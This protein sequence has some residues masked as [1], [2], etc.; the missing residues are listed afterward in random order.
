M[1]GQNH[2]KFMRRLI[3]FKLRGEGIEVPPGIQCNHPCSQLFNGCLSDK[4]LL[5]LFWLLVYLIWWQVT[6]TCHAVSKTKHIP[7]IHT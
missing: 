2:F 7:T 1:H 5:F 6:I 4:Q 3:K